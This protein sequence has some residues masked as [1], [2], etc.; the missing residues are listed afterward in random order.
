ME[1]NL[2]TYQYIPFGI[3]FKSRDFFIY[4]LKHNITKW[5]FYVVFLSVNHKHQFDMKDEFIYK[6]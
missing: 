1:F 5:T 4:I 2:V 3:P 6:T